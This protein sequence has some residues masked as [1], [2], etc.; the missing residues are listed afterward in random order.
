MSVPT[1]SNSPITPAATESKDWMKV[2]APELQSGSEDEAS[3]LNAKRGITTS[4]SG[5]R[6]SSNRKRW[7]G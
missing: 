2:T 3:V 5:G 6:R 4:K 7:R 1:K